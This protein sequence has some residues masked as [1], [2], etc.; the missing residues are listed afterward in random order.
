V[1]YA[2]ERGARQNGSTTSQDLLI[3][4]TESS[5]NAERLLKESLELMLRPGRAGTDAVVVAHSQRCLVLR[6]VLEDLVNNAGGAMRDRMRQHLRV[7]TFGNPGINWRVEN[8]P[9]RELRSFA[10]TTEH[11]A[12]RADFVARLGVLGPRKETV[13]DDNGYSNVFVNESWKGHLFG[14]QYSLD[15]DDYVEGDRSWLLT[16]A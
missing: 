1:E 11:F 15:D 9:A 4:R 8:N 13:G 16:T 5:R 12:N 7:N 2:G 14:A 10:R 3:S 6:L